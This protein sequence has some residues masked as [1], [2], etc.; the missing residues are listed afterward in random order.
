MQ[1]QFPKET[2]SCL[3][4]TA[5]EIK[6]D[7]YTQELKLPDALPDI[8]RVVGAWAQPL[9]R[10]KE[11]RG[12]GMSISGGLMAWV[13]Y[14]PEDSTEV[15]AVDTWI[16]IQQRWDFSD[17][18]RDG[19]MLADCRV[20]YVDAR[21]VSARKMVVRAGISMLG[22]ALEPKQLEY[23]VPGE[24]AE[25]MQLRPQTYML[26]LPAEAGEKVFSMEETLPAGE[27]GS[28][29]VLCYR[30]D[31]TVTEKKVMA[32]KLVFRG[33]L[34]LHMLC[35]SS[36]GEP[37]AADH[38][39]PFSQYT[40]L[41]HACG[42]DAEADVTLVFTSLE[43]NREEDGSLVLKAGLVGQYLIYDCK[44]VT[45]ITDAYS[46]CRQVQVQKEDWSVPGVL[47]RQ[48]L[49]VQVVTDTQTACLRHVD[50]SVLAEHPSI[51][52]T[53]EGIILECKGNFQLLGYDEGGVL[54]C[55]NIP[56]TAQKE[57]PAE[58]TVEITCACAGVTQPG[59][60]V[61]AD[62]VQ[63]QCENAVK[64]CA[65]T[66]TGIPMVTGVDMG[67]PRTPDPERPSLILRRCAD[68][69][70]WQLAKQTGSTVDAIREAN[71]LTE[72]FG[73]EKILLIPVP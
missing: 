24:M 6:H 35:R 32:D 22:E 44:A 65:Q 67:D 48:Q 46:T 66:G 30:V 1:L 11:W 18:Q 68:G 59:L 16:P 70:L 13:L 12:G 27:N 58:S 64:L 42:P 69:D 40:E 29:K 63:L 33:T 52:L 10:G 45:V 8:G 38:I 56:F 39:L 2:I 55:E 26:W 3:G 47:E 19:S 34:H 62:G 60:S 5:R 28:G 37:V 15:R 49:S 4:R 23:C 17:S 43:L 50:C 73:E 20:A 71:G 41:E 72:A 14:I 61:M 57:I 54:Q 36:E 7:E 53:S 9:I 21:S 25:D 31:A 51:Q